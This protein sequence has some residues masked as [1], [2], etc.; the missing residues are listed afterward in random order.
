M[1]EQILVFCT[2]PDADTADKI[3]REL[4]WRKLAACVSRGEKIQSVYRWE[5]AVESAAEF[6]LT[7]KTNSAQYKEVETAVI[8]L[9]PYDVPEIVAVPIVSGLPA[10]LE[11]IRQEANGK[12]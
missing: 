5:G 4:V 11:W 8:S 12:V 2:V 3:A 7:I 9:H 10:Y 1:T 6:N